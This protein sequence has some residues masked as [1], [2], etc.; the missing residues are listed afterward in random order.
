MQENYG[1]YS[2]LLAETVDSLNIKP[3]GSVRGLYPRRSR[4]LSENS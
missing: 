1:H 3:G 2:V 4:T